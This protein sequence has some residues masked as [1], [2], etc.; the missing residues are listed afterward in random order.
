MERHYL[1]FFLSKW[2][3]SMYLSRSAHNTVRRL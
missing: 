3:L 2:K 1:T